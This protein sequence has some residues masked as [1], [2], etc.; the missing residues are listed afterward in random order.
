MSSEREGPLSVAKT[1]PCRYQPGLS[2]S[3]GVLRLGAPWEH[4]RRQR[5]VEFSICGAAPT[6]APKPRA[7]AG[8]MLLKA[9]PTRR[10][11]PAA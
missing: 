5:V 1:R 10:A 6:P 9:K 2:L 4:R 8:P 11:G 7:V 3:A